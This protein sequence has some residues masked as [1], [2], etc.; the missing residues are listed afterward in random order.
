MLV[1]YTREQIEGLRDYL[2]S[3]PVPDDFDEFWALRMAEADEV[4]LEWELVAASAAMG[5]ADISPTAVAGAPCE[6][7]DLWFVGMGGTRLHAKYLVPTGTLALS[8]A[9]GGEPFRGTPLVLQLHGY[10]GTSRSWL[11]QMSF[12]GMGMA[13]LAFDCPGQGGPGDDV[14]GYHG[15]TVAGHLVAGLDGDPAG[16]YYVRC[17]QDIRI[18]C[19]IVRE[20]GGVDLDRVCVNG[21]S[22]GAGLGIA[23]AALNADLV[24]RAAILYPFLSDYRRV[25]EL[26]ADDIAYEGLRYYARWFDPTGTRADE[27]FGKLAYIDSVS[28]AHLVRAEVLFGTGLADIVCPPPTQCAVYNN[29][30]CP[31]RRVLF[32]DFGHEEIQAFDDMII[33]FFN[34]GLGPLPGG[35]CHE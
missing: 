27:V 11:E 31:K 29:L 34:A 21:A 19:R 2:G 3:T 18:L 15:T 35:E 13:I 8:Q 14:G 10:P 33:D 6:L 32:P 4:P 1:P 9:R 25:F 22:Q 17:H 24:S 12:V 20:L 30:A 5:G 26:E 28:F 7:S 23:T 16:L